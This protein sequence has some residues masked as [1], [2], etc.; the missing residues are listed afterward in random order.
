[1][2]RLFHIYVPGR[3]LVPVLS[4]ALL[5]VLAA[6]AATFAQFGSDTG[7][8][9]TYESGL[10]KILLAAGICM[11]CMHYY[12]LYD[13]RVLHSPGQMFTRIVQVLGTVCLILASLYYV[14]PGVRLNRDLLLIWVFLAGMSLIAWR[15]LFFTLNRSGRLA[16]KTLFLGAGPVAG[17]LAREIEL[18]PELGLS[19]V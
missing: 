15:K 19:L 9:L 17:A 6:L 1:M 5:I 4:E 10:F 13:S 14:Y 16:E 12:D 7:L 18:R 3:T 11:L 8:E 2:I